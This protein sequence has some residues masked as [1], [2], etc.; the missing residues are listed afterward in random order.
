MVE[1]IKYM[2][3]CGLSKQINGNISLNKERDG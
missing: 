2:H 3:G 1:A